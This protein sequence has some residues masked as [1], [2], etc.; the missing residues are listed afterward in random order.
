MICS[1][2]YVT[3]VEKLFWLGDGAVPQNLLAELRRL[4]RGWPAAGCATGVA[5]GGTG[6]AAGGD[7]ASQPP[8]RAHRL[9]DRRLRRHAHGATTSGSG[10][11][12]IVL[13]C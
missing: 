12:D 1:G 13:F 7:A 10:A 6:H 9:A 5:A 3:S 4:G 11:K 2:T 8:R